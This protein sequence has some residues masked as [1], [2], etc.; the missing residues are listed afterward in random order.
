MEALILREK[1]FRK[2]VPSVAE[3][4]HFVGAQRVRV[5]DRN[6]LHASRSEGIEAGQ[7]AAAGSQREWERLNA[8]AKE[9]NCGSPSLRE[10]LCIG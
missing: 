5:R 9:I 4:V 7:L 10:A 2:A 1:S 6:Q 3:L 8:V